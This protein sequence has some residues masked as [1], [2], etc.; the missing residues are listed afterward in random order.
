MRL[1]ILSATLA[2][3]SVIVG[4]SNEPERSYEWY[5][6]HYDEAKAKAIACS[7]M[8]EAQASIDRN[9]A[10]ARRAY[11]TPR[12]TTSVQFGSALPDRK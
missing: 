8:A 12:S 7:E 9:C 11:G 3:S 2:C 1:F 5:M 4:C 6:A 10:R